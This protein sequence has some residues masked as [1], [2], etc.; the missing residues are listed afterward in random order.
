[1]YTRCPACQ[2]AFRVT[3]ATLRAAHGQVVCATCH[4][5][6]DALFGLMDDAPTAAPL[7]P[8]P[9]PEPPPAATQTSPAPA[10]PGP[11]SAIEPA[12]EPTPE[13]VPA[14]APEPAAES[15]PVPELVVEPVPDGEGIVDEPPLDQ[16]AAALAEAG[17]L[18]EDLESPPSADELTLLHIPGSPPDWV[19]VGPPKVAQALAEAL[20]REAE[21][22]VAATSPPEAAYPQIHPAAEAAT[23]RPRQPPLIELD[24]DAPTGTWEPLPATAAE[25]SLPA[26][27]PDFPSAPDIE[28]AAVEPVFFRL[29]PTPVA[30]PV[31]SDLD[32]WTEPLPTERRRGWAWTT[33][34]LLLILLVMGQ[35]VHHWREPLARHP[36]LGSAINA[37]YGSLG[38]P[39][40]PERDLLAFQVTEG[41]VGAAPSPDALR[42]SAVIT[43]RAKHSLALPLLQVTLEDRYGAPIGRRAFGPAEYSADPAA[44]AAQQLA[45]GK[46]LN[47]TLDLADPG[48]DAVSFKLDLCLHTAA[49]LTCATDLRPASTTP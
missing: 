9:A 7:M 3:A 16:V 38:M 22:S 17:A 13:S 25:T 15:D 11:E 45:A 43:H 26:G 12:I 44:A 36:T 46:T 37:V 6:F 14:S 33:G 34:S 24:D 1:M 5:T 8:T 40:A 42:V 2:S 29:D 28:P 30:T 31:E 47:A 18:L 20:A 4:T 27:E 19:P 10:V 32:Q 21:S 49:G 41:T 23:P 39:L 48:T 35:G